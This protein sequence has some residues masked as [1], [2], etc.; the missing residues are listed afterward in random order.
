[1][2]IHI[3][4]HMCVYIYIYI[5]IYTSSNIRS[6][7]IPSPISLLRYMQIQTRHKH[8][9]L[10][11]VF[12]RQL[13]KTKQGNKKPTAIGSCHV[14]TIQPVCNTPLSRPALNYIKAKRAQVR[15]QKEMCYCFFFSANQNRGNLHTAVSWVQQCLVHN[16]HSSIFLPNYFCK[17]IINSEL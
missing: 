6:T 9:Q 17:I 13:T 10:L 14:S 2:Y 16:L 7:P 15:E 5:Y 11:P 12:L 8:F 4:I 3:Y 1:M